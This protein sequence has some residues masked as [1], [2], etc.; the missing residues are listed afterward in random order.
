M[1]RLSKRRSGCTVYG[2]VTESLSV[3][4][5]CRGK[6]KRI[7]AFQKM[8]NENDRLHC[9]KEVEHDTENEDAKSAMIRKSENDTKVLLMMVNK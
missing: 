3:Q 7:S 1:T 4:E 5:H 8:E 6:R 2:T 9:G